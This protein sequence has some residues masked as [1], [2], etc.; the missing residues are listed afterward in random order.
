[1]A[2]PVM[3]FFT[4]QDKARK[5]TR[6]L[7]VLFAI[8]ILLLAGS[9]YMALA[10]VWAFGEPAYAYDSSY[11]GP[12]PGLWQPELFTGVLIFVALIVS[13][14][15]FYMTNK[16]KGGGETVARGL[17]GRPIPPDTRNFHE[18][19][20]LNVVEEMALASGVTVPQVYLLENESSINAFAAG[21]DRDGAVIGVTRGM[22]ELLNR[23]EQQGVIAHEFS[24]ILNGDM[25]MNIR[26]IGLIHGILLISVMGNLMIRS[27]RY[28]RGGGK[29]KGG[30]IILAIVVLGLAMYVLGY[31]G[32]LFGRMIK[33]A[34][35][36]Q[37]E[38]L[39]D[40]SAVQFTR[41]PPGLA[42]ALKKIG[43][44]QAGSRIQNV[45]AEE[46]SHLFFGNG[47]RRNGLFSTHPPLLERIRLLEPQ[48]DGQF[49]IPVKIQPAE[50]SASNA[51]TTRKNPLDPI[52][53][54]GL[55]AHMKY[56]VLSHLAEDP[57]S[58]SELVG[59]P[60]PEH[61]QVVEQMLAGLPSQLQEAARTTHGAQGL[62]YAI[63]L[64]ASPEIRER[65]WETL[66]AGT[67]PEV[68]KATRDLFPGV[69]NRH[70]QDR[71]ML[72]EL[73][74]PALRTLGGDAYHP[75]RNT[76]ISLMEADQQITLFE[77]A[78]MNLLTGTLD[79]HYKAVKTPPAGIYSL[80]SLARESSLLLSMLAHLG[81]PEQ[82]AA[83]LA[84]TSGR[85]RLGKDAEAITLLPAGDCSLGEI[86]N[87]LKK[88]RTL[89]APLKRGLVTACFRCITHDRNVT[90]DEGELFRA[91]AMALDCP[92]P[93]WLGHA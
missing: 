48:F 16:L 82:S 42:G 67:S 35:S 27:L 73:C 71:M 21:F 47:L 6:L 41:N 45:H 8:A 39:A 55:G 72:V 20:I 5:R 83:E 22:I 26:L 13:I 87:A 29:N 12:Q 1:M 18:R 11:A 31:I 74:V 63:L 66:S 36:R 90:P 32:V 60:H 23:E 77:Y 91:I 43:G 92:V 88:L 75:F 59:N 78:I 58:I 69:E 28:M 53:I 2:G 15:S 10:A 17:G 86:D 3:D 54:P 40:A 24:H 30:A 84:F 46:A 33:S 89:A 49:P 70:R 79:R 56:P 85:K 4:R 14:G 25:R 7:V 65:Q 62:M 68:L 44:A 52:K 64:D 93:P 9:L 61:M 37:R 34:V 38:Y 51:A 19:R 81:N 76:A 57:D 80:R 50:D